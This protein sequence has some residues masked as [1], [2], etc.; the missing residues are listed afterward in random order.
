MVDVLDRDGPARAQRPAQARAGGR[1]VAQV[2]E[3]EARVD[4]VK[5]LV[6]EL[7]AD[8]AAP[9]T[10]PGRELE[11]DVAATAADVQAARALADGDAVQQ[12]ERRVVH[13]APEHAQALT[14]GEPAANDVGGCRRHAPMVRPLA[15]A[16][17]ENR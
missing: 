13:A 5:L 14:P 8:D 10:H 15:P 17:N 7:D 3:Q 11:R 2:A 12:R 9:V 1:G 4:E 16:A 6:V